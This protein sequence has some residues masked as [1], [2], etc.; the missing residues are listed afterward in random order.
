VSFCGLTLTG[1][2]ENGAKNKKARVR[3]PFGASGLLY[4]PLYVSIPRRNS[5]RNIPLLE[6]ALNHVNSATCIFLIATSCPCCDSLVP[7]GVEGWPFSPLATSHSPLVFS[8][9]RFG[10]M[11]LL[12]ALVAEEGFAAQANF[13]ALDG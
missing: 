4:V 12:V 5:N 3:L 8:P 1:G 2:G 13:V 10:L 7:N 11:L 9:R 6:G